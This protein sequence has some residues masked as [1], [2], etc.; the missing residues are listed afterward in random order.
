M[1]ILS[2]VAGIALVLAGL[3]GWQYYYPATPLI[4]G[5]GMPGPR[6]D[7]DR[8]CVGRYRLYLGMR[9]ITRQIQC[10]GSAN[11]QVVWRQDEIDMDALTRQVTHGMRTLAPADS[12][13]WSTERDSIRNAL[14]I[15]GGRAI[16]CYAPYG[17]NPPWIVSEEAWR[18]RDYSVRLVAYNFAPPWHSPYGPPPWLLQLD[19]YPGDPPGCGATNATTHP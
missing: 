10:R 18:F 14:T 1:K 11:H 3:M 6:A 19:G 5:L 15:T 17:K 12:T 16:P 7:T 4:A 2:V 9:L 13:L 8:R